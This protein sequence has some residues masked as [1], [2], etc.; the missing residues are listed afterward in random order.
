MVVDARKRYEI[1][2]GKR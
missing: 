2:C 1:V